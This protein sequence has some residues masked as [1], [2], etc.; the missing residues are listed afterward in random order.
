V[1]PPN[2]ARFDVIVVGGGICGL[3]TARLLARDGRSVAVVEAGPIA[4]GVTGYTTAKVTALQATVISDIASRLG[5]ERAAAYAAAN[6]AAVEQV[7]ALVSDDAIECDFERAPACTYAA[8]DDQVEHVE[9][10]HAATSAAGLPTRLDPAT[11]LPFGVPAAVWLDGQA[12]FHPRRYCLGLARAL[13]SAGGALFEHTRALRIA[14]PAG[15]CVV[16]TDWGE[17]RAA[18]VVVATHLPFPN[19]GSF[20]AR[21][22][23]SRSYAVAARVGGDRI[24]GMYINTGPPTRSIRSTADGWTIIGGEGHKAGRDDDTRRRYQSLERWAT[25]TFGTKEIGYRWSAHDYETVDGMPYV[26]RISSR[27]DHVWVATGFRKWGMTN[28]TAAAMILTD[29]IA[30]R[31]NPWAE[32]FD[33]TRILPGASLA[34][35]VKENLDVGKRL[36]GDR[37]RSWRP[38][39]AAEL[40]PGEG[41]IVDLDGDTV[42]AFRGDDGVLHAVSASC[43]HLGCRVTF[44]TAERSWDCPCHGSRFDIDGRLLEGPAVADLHP[45]SGAGKVSPSQA[46]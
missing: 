36:V 34:T 2:Q 3:T 42:A 17:L 37:V 23:A 15:V 8:T 41:A 35:L 12:Q 43:T 4:A 31:G 30:D 11:E 6:A 25:D 1:P 14:K 19:A 13:T 10:E 39:P 33:S 27:R 16:T 24:G 7:A 21:A 5:R 46:G 26:G 9:N 29:L 18:D 20:F 32:A 40:G 22:H 44:N 45:R 38:R 28:G